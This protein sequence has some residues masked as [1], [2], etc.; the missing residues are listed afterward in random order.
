MG[1]MSIDAETLRQTTVKQV[2]I[3]YYSFMKTLSPHV[4]S[5]LPAMALGGALALAGPAVASSKKPKAKKFE[6]PPVDETPIAGEVGGHASFAP[7]VKKVAPGVVKVF[8][9]TKIH[10]T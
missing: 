3:N 1:L 8:T 6:A 10:N 9:T 2:N 5:R 7:V 4:T